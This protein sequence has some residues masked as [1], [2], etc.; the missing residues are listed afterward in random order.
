MQNQWV[1]DIGYQFV[2]FGI[3]L[4]K[5]TI[6]TVIRKVGK[7]RY[8]RK[9][10]PVVHSYGTLGISAYYLSAGKIP[11]FY[12]QETPGSA[13]T[14]NEQEY[15]PTDMAGVISYG[16]QIYGSISRRYGARLYVGMNI[17]YISKTL[18]DEYAAS[19][20]AGDLALLYQPPGGKFGIGFNAQNSG[21]G[22]AFDQE[23]SPLPADMKAGVSYASE[24]LDNDFIFAVDYHNAAQAVCVG[25]EYN[26]WDL[27]TLR[28]GYKASG[29]LDGGLRAGMGIGT[30]SL[31]FD[32]AYTP[33]GVLGET[34]RVSLNFRF[35]ERPTTIEVLN[36]MVGKHYQRGN[37]YYQRDKLILAYQEFESVVLLDSMHPE[38]TKKLKRIK[39]AFKEFKTKAEAEKR[40]KE[41]AEQIKLGK[42]YFD[43]G[44]FENAKMQFNTVLKLQ[45]NNKEAKSYLAKIEKSYKE[46]T[47][48]QIVELLKE[49]KLLYSK[50]K[51]ADTEIR[52]EKILEYD[53]K[54]V[55]AKKY[56]AMTQ[57]K[58]K[59]I[60]KE[61][62]AKEREEKIQ[63]LYKNSVNLYNKDNWSKAINGFKSVLKYDPN[64]KKA[65]EYLAKARSAYKKQK[66]EDAVKS[67]EYY[68]QGLKQYV[69]G[70]IDKAIELWDRA[71]KLNPA[72]IKAKKGLER[73]R[74]ERKK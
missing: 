53:P 57:K 24:F 10:P 36:E 46:F 52:C 42:K 54:H 74:K 8:R 17:K 32:Y 62:K 9:L 56:L 73:A 43:E 20:V 34:H 44:E 18:T 2:G 61:K 47:N 25:T 67:K 41:I 39:L 31:R 51:Y 29:H 58:L 64:H 13:G 26:F 14:S 69:A 11:G 55:E 68:T 45:P 12:G 70:N 38:A 30:R 60:G 63:E 7:K 6:K 5:T 71:V 23:V 35:G 72:N 65:K 27:I 3:P 59:A 21:T 40:R 15:I 33:F 48:R 22:L 66:A 1:A 49:A 50:E 37:M 4:R 19:T 28:F 16:R